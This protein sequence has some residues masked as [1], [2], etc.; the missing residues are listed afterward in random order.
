VGKCL[1]NLESIHPFI[2]APFWTPLEVIINGNM[3][4]A[5]K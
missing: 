1:D 4:I 5:M 3:E 2:A